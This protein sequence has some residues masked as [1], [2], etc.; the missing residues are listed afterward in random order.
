MVFSSI[1]FIF[2]FLPIAMGIYFLT[3]KKLK[4]LSLLILSLI[5]YSWGE[6]RYFL[7]MIASIFVD[8]FISINIEKNNK[9]KKIK[10]LL[11]A[12]SII[13]NVGI[14]FFFKYI[15]FF[16]ENINSIFNMSL[17]NVKITLP[18]GISFYT[19]QT[20]SYTIDVFLGKVKAEKNI[21]NFGAFVCLFPQLIAGPIVKYI[22]I[23]KELKNRDINLDEIQEGIRLFILGLGSKV[24][25][26][27]NIG[28]LWNEVETMGF[29]NISTI[30]A[31]M[32]IIAFSL[33]IYFDFNG[34]SL[35]AIGLGKILGFNFPNNFNYPYESRSITEF[36]R[37]WHITLGQWFK[38][39]V[40]IPLGGNRL[41]RA[42]TYFNLFIVWFLTGLW[43]GAS[44]NFIL[45]GLYFGVVLIFE[46]L[47][48]LEFLKKLPNWIKHFYTM[49]LVIIGFVLFEID[50]L[51]GV[52]N[53]LI[54]MFNF[55]NIIVDDVFLYY[56][57]PNITLIIFAIIAST[58]IIKIILD[59]YKY[60]RI[61]TLIF[62]MIL[63][64]SF[65]VDASFNPFLYFRF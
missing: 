55:K 16:I 45:W 35:M 43:H 63:S 54:S 21:I 39:Y 13:F 53:Y 29:N 49:F 42:R 64:T 59:R 12:I 33:Q 50:S 1:L 22:D 8:Y 3:P 57:I 34:Y 7:L 46:K 4:N 28:S 20:M 31:W 38:Q 15:N 44:Y 26:A 18:L 60:I 37:R 52:Y 19:F 27:N 61:I 51:N 48:L 24:L 23:S 36:W 58:P 5:F 40:Y 30:L 62:G 47:F 17:N 25:I 2:R 32:G 65:L 56:L 11:L 9:N 6:P 41:G 14:L 10:I